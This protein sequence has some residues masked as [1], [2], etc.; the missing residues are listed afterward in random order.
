MS[1]KF[2]IAV[3]GNLA[4]FPITQSLRSRL[5]EVVPGITH[6]HDVT[7]DILMRVGNGYNP[8]YHEIRWSGPLYALK[9][10]ETHPWH[11][12]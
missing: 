8:K 1:R 2:H 9:T 5:L 10:F 7:R 6:M 11:T 4:E 3:F 12:D